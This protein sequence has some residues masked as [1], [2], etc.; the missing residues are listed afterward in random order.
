MEFRIIR[1]RRRTI[2]IQISA[3]GEVIVKAPYGMTLKDIGDFVER[4]SSWIEK[5]VARRR[6][7]MAV[8]KL[9]EEEIEELMN[10]ALKVIPERVRF[11]AEKMGVTYGR[12]TIRAQKTRWGSC[13]AKGNLSFNFLLMLVPDDVM[14][15]VIVHE[16]AH[17]KEMNHSA[18]FYEVVLK[19]CPEYRR[20][21]A[22]LKENGP[23]LMRRLVG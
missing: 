22:W 9:S 11:Y 7:D 16:L 12:I 20:H 19:A 23:M 6:P 15:S 18:A 21:D 2:C 14:D 13:S 1:S 5:H 4:K 8:R 10:R 17:R 3:T